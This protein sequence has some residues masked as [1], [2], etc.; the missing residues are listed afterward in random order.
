MS[1]PP[2]ERRVVVALSPLDAF[3]VFARQIHIWWPRA[4]TS[5]G[6][7]LRHIEIEPFPD[8]RVFETSLAGEE[9][10]WGT[11]LAYQPGELLELH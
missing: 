10:G 2:I 6:D 8:G 5:S 11:V 9:V 4:F 7:A 3:D 1:I